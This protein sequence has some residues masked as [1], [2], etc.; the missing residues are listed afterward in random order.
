MAAL[1]V[2]VVVV[3]AA[4]TL[5]THR[6]VQAPVQAR[7]RRLL[8]SRQLLRTAT[9]IHTHRRHRDMARPLVRAQA[10][11]FHSPAAAGAAAAE[12]AGLQ[13][14]LLECSLH[15]SLQPRDELPRPLQ[16]SARWQLKWALRC[17]MQAV[18]AV[19]AAM[20][21]RVGLACSLRSS[22]VDRQWRHTQ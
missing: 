4:L 15:P 22:P 7:R 17:P 5:P 6:W 9:R 10:I 18:A 3:V 19:V 8:A 12:A 2:V 14:L 11:L 1:L 21:W 13:L 20:P 16:C